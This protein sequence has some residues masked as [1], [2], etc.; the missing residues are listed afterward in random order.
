MVTA[1]RS[2]RT[3]ITSSHES[4]IGRTGRSRSSRLRILGWILLPTAVVLALSWI[5]TRAV[6]LDRL[7][8]G[9][10]QEL[11]GEVSELRLLADE[12]TDPNTGAAFADPETLLRQY[13]SRSIPDANETMFAV[14]DG[15]VVARTGDT[16]PVRIDKLPDLLDEVKSLTGVGYGDL[17]TSAGDVRYVAVPVVVE[18]STSE[19]ALVVGIFRDLESTD[20][21]D[22]LATWLLLSIAAL[23]MATVIGWFVAGRVLSPVRQMAGTA[24]QISAEQLGRRI[25]LSG[26]GDELDD[27]AESFNGM[28]DRLDR[29]FAAQRAFVDDAG[30]ELRTPLTIIRGNLELMQSRPEE[31]AEG[32]AIALEEVDRMA[33]IV[34]DLQTLTKST[35]PGFVQVQD[36]S[37]DEVS[38]DVLRRAHALA[39]RKWVLDA[40]TDGTCRID[41]QRVT[42]ALVQL[43]DNA[44]RH[45]QAGDEIGVGSELTSDEV[46]F[47]V[48]D[49]GPGIQQADRERVFDRFVS[50]GGEGAG[51]G[52]SIVSAIAQA[53]GG[54]VHYKDTPNGGATFTIVLPRRTD[55]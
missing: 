46:R 43:V 28:L 40:R 55:G 47:W 44:V 38:D 51:L 23:V 49:T 7:N 18:G 24:R 34:H 6:L 15:Q 42:Q 20:I 37:C 36:V 48:R 32:T 35:Q 12:G 52:L 31:R 41:R 19:G 14:V 21:E 29:A 27:L 11:A 17:S 22:S 25:P 30:H 16:P 4:S 10:T 1:K 39:E 13:L 8:D 33:R 26:R 54:D 45:T 3:S 53:H 50:S 9:I 2:R 5:T